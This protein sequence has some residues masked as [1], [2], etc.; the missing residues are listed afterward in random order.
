MDQKI[1]ITSVI[2]SE[3][4]LYRLHQ[5]M[6]DNGFVNISQVCLILIDIVPAQK[7]VFGTFGPTCK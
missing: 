2:R 3:R 1:T 6:K 5:A 7:V 4:E